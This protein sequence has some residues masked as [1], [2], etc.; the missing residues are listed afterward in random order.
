MIQDT[1]I[2]Y[3]KE[4]VSKQEINRYVTK[5]MRDRFFSRELSKETGEKYIKEEKED[6]FWFRD[7]E[8]Y[9]TIVETDVGIRLIFKTK[10]INNAL[11]FYFY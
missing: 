1:R 4:K 8:G 7:E 2:V 5:E 10:D 11:L 3:S 9:I 6:I